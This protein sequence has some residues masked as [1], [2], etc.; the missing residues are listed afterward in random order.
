MAV[1]IQVVQGYPSV[2]GPTEFSQESLERLSVE[3]LD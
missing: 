2:V 3:S 1:V